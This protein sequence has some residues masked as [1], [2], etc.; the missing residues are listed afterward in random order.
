MTESH[1]AII[2]SRARPAPEHVYLFR[3]FLPPSS[4]REIV[5]PFGGP[6]KLYESCRD[7]MVEAVPALIEFL[8]KLTSKA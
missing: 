7:E 6:L 3:E 2:Q 5:D 1:R 4:S 8:R